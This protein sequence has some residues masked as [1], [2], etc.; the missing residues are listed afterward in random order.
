MLGG[1]ASLHDDIAAYDGPVDGVVACNDAGAIWP[2]DLDA[3]VSLHSQFFARKGWLAKRAQAG[4]PPAR[5]IYSH[6]FGH[7]DAPTGPNVR[8]THCQFPGV[9]V[10]G[11][12]GLFA[13]KVALIDLGFERAVLCGIPISPTPHFFDDVPWKDA[14]GMR[15]RWLAIPDEYRARMRSMSGWTRTLLGGPDADTQKHDR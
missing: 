1:A 2:G 4:L 13:A 7:K 12:S 14:E 9:E 15:S 5:A 11:S 6:D 3:W 8:R 10:G